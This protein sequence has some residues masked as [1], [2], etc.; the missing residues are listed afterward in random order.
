[1]IDTNPPGA[2]S[3]AAIEVAVAEALAH[4]GLAAR[5]RA[6][7]GAAW[8]EASSRLAYVPVDYS[9][10]M[11]DYQL[12][13]WSSDGAPARD[14]SLVLLHDRHPCGIWPLSA[15]FAPATG[16]N[17]GSNGGAVL[18][19]LFADGLPDKSH[20]SIT[21]QCLEFLA[22]ACGR[23]GQRTIESLTPHAANAGDLG[24]WHDR[25]LR[26]G[27][28]ATLRHELFLDLSPPLEEIRSS[29][30][31]SYKALVSAGSRLWQVEVASGPCP[32]AWDEFRLLHLAVAGRATRS[33]DSWRLQHEA[34]AA[35]DAFFVS[36]RDGSG[37]MTGGGLFH[38][39]AHEALY[40]IGA[41]DRA[42]FD[43]PLG[44]V[45][46][47]QAIG[48]MKRRGLRWYRLGARAYPSD[49]PAP[50]GKEIA[51]SAFKDGFAS[52]LFPRCLVRHELP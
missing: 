1:M 28:S 17:I 31:K 40:A 3:H 44:H 13:Y 4:S 22:A 8:R 36:L 48:E 35:G 11:V 23:A 33:L 46:Q 32:Q 14:L 20:K 34:I 41:Y 49:V 18:P 15:K 47:F 10:A 16:W 24:D 45:V 30:R 52:H 43:K 25:L 37:R 2:G 9:D 6:E 38:V 42:L 39:T 26:G 7:A 12:A 27:A 50:S 51:I 29:F 21:G 19:P 5:P